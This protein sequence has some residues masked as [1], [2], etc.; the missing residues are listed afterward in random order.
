MPTENNSDDQ[1]LLLEEIIE[2]IKA[3]ESELLR[4][5][6]LNRIKAEVE[7]KIQS[8]EPTK[9]RS[10]YAQIVALSGDWKPSASCHFPPFQRVLRNYCSAMPKASDLAPQGTGRR[11]RPHRYI[12]FGC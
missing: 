7:V 6:Q 8:K 11:M 2:I 3:S 1:N 10:A 12:G 9:C 5:H 4:Q